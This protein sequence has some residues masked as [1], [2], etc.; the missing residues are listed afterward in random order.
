MLRWGDPS[1]SRYPSKIAAAALFPFQVA[2]LFGIETARSRRVYQSTNPA[3]K[4]RQ[5]I[6]GDTYIPYE[7]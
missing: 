7:V 1:I 6:A 3:M 4:K 2:G 5:S